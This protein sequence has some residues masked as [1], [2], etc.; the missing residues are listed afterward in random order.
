MLQWLPSLMITLFFVPNALDKIMNANQANKI[1]SNPSILIA[2][3]IFL[4]I[5]TVLF[6]H[7]KTVLIGGSLLALYMTLIV[8]IHI[9]KGKAYDVTLLI[10]IGIVFATYI[11]TSHYFHKHHTSTS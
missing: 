5:A 11:R 6:L 8:G 10:V 9:Y 4:L 7:P 3:G 1:I 2:T